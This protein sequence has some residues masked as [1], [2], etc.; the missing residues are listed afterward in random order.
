LHYQPQ[1]TLRAGALGISAMVR[2]A[3]PELGL[4]GPERFLP[5]AEDGGLL[6]PLVEWL[7][8]TA[9]AQAL[10]W[11][12]LGL[13]PVHLALPLPTHR[14]LAWTELTARLQSCLRGA[15]L[16][17]ARLEVEIPEPVLLADAAA[18]GAGL[19]ALDRTGVRIALGGFGSGPMS[20]RGLPLDLLDT[21]KLARELHHDVPHDRRRSALVK[22]MV[23][24]AKDL[25]MRVVADAVDR[26]DQLGF[27]R[28]AGCDAVQVFMSCPPLP[29]AACT[30][31]LRQ[32]SSRRGA[33]PEGAAQ[34]PGGAD[35]ARL[36]AGAD[37]AR[38]GNAGPL[39]R[40]G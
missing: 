18:G 31:W 1:V 10:C 3:H 38:P 5:L 26:H 32:A 8:E 40:A 4:I 13:G 39:S 24:L 2:W 30:G 36:P 23:C 34:P 37:G 35:G 14:K 22:A 11:S 25:G 33:T 27:L 19:A 7:C 12:E 16:S 21:I 20:L 28:R 29:A 9:C 15:G 17:P 6:P